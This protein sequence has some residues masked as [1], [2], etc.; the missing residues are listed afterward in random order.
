MTGGSG[1]KGFGSVG[2]TGV[3]GVG[4]GSP[5]GPGCGSPGTGG[6]GGGA[7]SGFGTE[8]WGRSSVRIVMRN[9]FPSTGAGK[10]NGQR[11][12]RPSSRTALEPSH[13]LPLR[14]R[15]GR[16][17]RRSTRF[18]CAMSSAS[19]RINCFCMH[20]ILRNGR[21][22]RRPCQLPL[23]TLVIHG[24]GDGSL[25]WRAPEFAPMR[26]LLTASCNVSHATELTPHSLAFL[27]RRQGP[28][29][30]RAPFRSAT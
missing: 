22:P 19:N 21:V 14:A 13:G 2:G 28:E 5:G 18:R 7:G 25:L 17:G 3:G 4:K 16:H 11:E 23:P 9:R 10:P 20:G 27:R 12:W 26:R 6:I 29:R 24:D 15:P 8:D 1:G 30:H